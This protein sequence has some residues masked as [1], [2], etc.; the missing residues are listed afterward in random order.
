M[1]N[2][3]TAEDILSLGWTESKFRDAMGNGKIF[4]YMHRHPESNRLTLYK[5]TKENSHRMDDKRFFLAWHI[6]NSVSDYEG[7]LNI[8]LENKTDL[9]KLMK[10]L[11]IK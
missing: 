4:I 6:I 8:V 7:E 9:E 11:D 5:L 1:D 3:I 2:N 10:L